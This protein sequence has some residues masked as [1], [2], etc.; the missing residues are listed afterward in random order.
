MN[1]HSKFLENICGALSIHILLIISY[2]ELMFKNFQ[3]LSERLNLIF[4]KNYLEIKHILLS[5]AQTFVL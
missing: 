5:F 4:F 2:F 1:K 3:A